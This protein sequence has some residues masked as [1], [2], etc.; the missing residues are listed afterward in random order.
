M[1]GLICGFA[2]VRWG[3]GDGAA[4]L[5][6]LPIPG[7]MPAL[8][9][10]GETVRWRNADQARAWCWEAVFGPGPF[11]VVGRVDH[12]DRGLAAGLIVRTPL[13]EWEI[14]EV[15]LALADE[16][17]GCRTGLAANAIRPELREG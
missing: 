5:A 7:L 8:P 1:R 9:R 12:S 15:W 10:P 14:S 17:G 2:Q 13:G 16:P 3:T 11:Q 6:P 4:A